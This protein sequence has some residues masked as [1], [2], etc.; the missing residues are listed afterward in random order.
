VEK[1]GTR[2]PPFRRLCV[3]SAALADVLAHARAEAP[4]ECC[5]LLAGRVDGDAGR[6]TRGFRL[7]NVA[8]DPLTRCV[9]EPRGTFAAEKAMLAEGL[10]V[11]AVYHSHPSSPPVPSRTDLEWN[12]SPNVVTLI[13]SPASDPPAVRGWWLTEVDYR[14]AEWEEGGEVDDPSGGDRG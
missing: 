11:L 1:E 13:V 6:V 8:P 7:V 9:S 4:R 12:Y 2:P 14:E 3:P 5:G 10:Q